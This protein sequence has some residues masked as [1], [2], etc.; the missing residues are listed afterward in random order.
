[1]NEIFIV[2]AL[3]IVIFSM[4]LYLLLMIRQIGG[5]IEKFSKVQ[6]IL[7]LISGVYIS[8]SLMQ[9]LPKSSQLSHNYYQELQNELKTDHISI[10][11]IEFLVF[12]LSFSLILFVEKVVG[13]DYEEQQ[14]ELLED[15]IIMQEMQEIKSEHIGNH[16]QNTQSQLQ[17][18]LICHNNSIIFVK[19]Q[20][21]NEELNNDHSEN[22]FKICNFICINFSLFLLAFSLGYTNYLDHFLYQQ[23]PALFYLPLIASALQISL[24][25]NSKLNQYQKDRIYNAFIAI[26]LL[27]FIFGFIFSFYKNYLVQSFLIAF[28]SG[29]I[30]YIS[31]MKII[32]KFY[33]K[34]QN[35]MDYYLYFS[36]GYLGT[37]Y[38]LY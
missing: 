23:I 7:L 15:I 33:G 32:Q 21:I 17:E 26:I 29:T 8:V 11:P 37:S 6:Q 12:C 34:H 31:T 4:L 14:D 20:D 28:N 19:Q 27:G 10:F 16:E 1:M 22:H 24:K 5:F 36:I 9:L 30:L 18:N 3:K 35:K 13:Y 38:L 2:Q 25:Q